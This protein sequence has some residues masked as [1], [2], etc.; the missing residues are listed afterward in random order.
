[1]IIFSLYISK[2]AASDSWDNINFGLPYLSQE[3]MILS[4]LLILSW[5]FSYGLTNYRTTAFVNLWLTPSKNQKIE[6]Q[7][8]NR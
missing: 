7:Q 6:K 2:Q 8:Q 4:Q 3:S 1:M 5:A